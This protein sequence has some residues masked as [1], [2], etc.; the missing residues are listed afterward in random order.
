[1]NLYYLM[2]PSLFK[3]KNKKANYSIYIIILINCVCKN[4][5]T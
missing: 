2:M 4:L 5:N 3:H 1:M